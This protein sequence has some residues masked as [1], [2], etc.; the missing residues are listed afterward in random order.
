[1]PTRMLRGAWTVTWRRIARRTRRSVGECAQRSPVFRRAR[2]RS[3]V[4]S[5]SSSGSASTSWAGACEPMAWSASPA[6]AT[7]GW[8]PASSRWS[9]NVAGWTPSSCSLRGRGKHPASRGS[10]TGPRWPRSWW[11][12]RLFPRLGMIPILPEATPGA[13]RE[14]LADARAVLGHGSCLVIFPEKGPPSPR[15]QTRTIAPGATWLAAAG[16]VPLVPV[17]IGGFLETGL[18]TRY[19]AARP[20]AAGPA[21]VPARH[22]ERPAGRARHDRIARGDTCPRGRRA[23]D[24]ERPDERAPPAPLDGPSLPL[25]ACPAGELPG[26]EARPVGRGLTDGLGKNEWPS[27][28]SA[29]RRPSGHRSRTRATL[30]GRRSPG[31]GSVV[32]WP[33]RPT[34]ACR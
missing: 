8:C 25:T 14:H 22:R 27:P 32:R 18:G 19:R 12:R 23:R 34:A 24:L 13:V 21:G 26:T 16:N 1:M 31:Y 30:A 15:G 10:A 20:R 29:R 9:P 2:P 4:S 17:A 6:I 11:R 7:A 33:L 28:A 3:T 5:A